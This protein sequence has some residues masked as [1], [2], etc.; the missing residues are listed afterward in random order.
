MEI[1]NNN[2][3]TTFGNVYVTSK[4]AEKLLNKADRMMKAIPNVTYLNVNIPEGHSKPLWSVY[5][6]L[7]KERQ[8]KNPN[9]IIIDIANKAKQLL[10]VR[11][12]DAKGYTHNSYM[13][14]AMPKIGSLN[15]LAPTNDSY[16]TYY[17]SL[18]S[19]K[20][21]TS[22]FLDVLDRAEYE[23]D[24]LLEAI[25]ERKISRKELPK[26]KKA[27]NETKILKRQ[28]KEKRKIVP[29]TQKP[30]EKLRKLLAP[31]E[32]PAKPAPKTKDKLPRKAKKEMKKLFEN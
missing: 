2:C 23:A 26:Q 16:R 5:S 17:Q 15:E 3:R 13:V 8:L 27:P 1:Q 32:K 22:E 28:E 20:Y 21:G 11:I 18:D 19:K 30:F 6:K 10:S 4:E 24:S 12:L 29:H 9:N 14:S 25:P 31:Q 7:I